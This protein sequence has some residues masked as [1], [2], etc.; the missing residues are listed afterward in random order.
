[1]NKRYLIIGLGNP[2]KEYDGTRHNIGFRCADALVRAYGLT[3]EKGKKSKA[4]VAD[5]II[6]G[7]RALVIKPQT[8][9]NLSGSSAQGIAAFYQIPPERIIVIYDDMDIPLG[10][11]RIRAKGGAGG[12]RGL[13]DIINRLGASNIAR[14]RVGI[15]RPP[16]RMEPSA[17]VLRR[18]DAEELP[19]IEEATQRV[20]KTVE[21]WLTHGIDMAMNQYNGSA[22]EVTARAVQ[23][24]K[25]E[26]PEEN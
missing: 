20:V 6:A 11:L 18:F 8:Y 1:M 14:V 3:Y 13:Q 26:Q 22:E 16:E 10:T 17:H 23:H 15:G 9:M 25:S 24:S 21:T 5:G 12:H 2:G 4:K 7:K 19:V